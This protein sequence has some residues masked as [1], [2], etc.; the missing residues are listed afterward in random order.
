MAFLRRCL[1]EVRSLGGDWQPGEDW[2]D[3]PTHDVE[4][5]ASTVNASLP[6]ELQS[7]P[8]HGC[9]A[10]AE[11]VSRTLSRVLDRADPPIHSAANNED[12]LHEHAHR[13][14]WSRSR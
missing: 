13:I 4:P 12:D 2:L 6:F 5:A 11:R 9:A 3:R 10:H 14:G 7:T 1:Q 8:A